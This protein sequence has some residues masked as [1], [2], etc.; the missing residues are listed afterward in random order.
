MAISLSATSDIGA[1]ANAIG[2]LA[3]LAEAIIKANPTAAADALARI[4]DH[5]KW[6]QGLFPTPKVG[7]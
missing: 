7:A 3:S 6:L 5:M 1:V 4:D 2:A